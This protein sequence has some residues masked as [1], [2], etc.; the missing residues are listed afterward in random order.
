MRASCWSR[1][2]GSIWFGLYGGL[3]HW[4]APNK[5]QARWESFRHDGNQ[6]DS[7]GND[8]VVSLTEDDAG[9]IWIGTANGLSVYDV[10]QRKMRTFRNDPA[11]AQS[12]GDNLIR[13]VYQSGD[14]ALWI[15]TQSGLDRLDVPGAENPHFAHYTTAHGS[16]R[17]DGVRHP[18][19]RAP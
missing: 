8:T 19:R 3:S 15:G 10:K 17:R 14:G 16:A 2:D 11:N 4:I 1:R 5:P 7:L 9:R 6:A 13:T 18:R 12:L